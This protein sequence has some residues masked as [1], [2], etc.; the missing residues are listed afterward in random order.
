MAKNTETINTLKEGNTKLAAAYN[1]Y[2]LKDV[3]YDS[4]IESKKKTFYDLKFQYENM[5]ASNALMITLL[6]KNNEALTE[7]LKT[8]DSTSKTLSTT[9]NTLTTYL[10]EVKSG[11]KELSSGLTLLES[12]VNTLSSKTK[13]LAN[14]AKTLETGMNSLDEGIKKFNKS[15]IGA[16]SSMANSAKSYTNKVEALKDLS[17]NYQIFAGKKGD[18]DSTTK[19]ILNVDGVKSSTESNVVTST[20][21]KKSFWELLKGLFTK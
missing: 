11:T 19:F 21:T 12:G 2:G 14:G 6:E 3:T 16:I 17:D 1:K 10:K 9:L 13:E 5:Y 18:T 20:S 8:M 15:G 7:T 4:L